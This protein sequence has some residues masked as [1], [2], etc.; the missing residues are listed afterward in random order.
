MIT[1]VN[2]TISYDSV[3]LIIAKAMGNLELNQQINVDETK[4]TADEFALLKKYLE[5]QNYKQ[6]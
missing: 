5:Q 4:I 1:F 2:Q 6:Q 3:A